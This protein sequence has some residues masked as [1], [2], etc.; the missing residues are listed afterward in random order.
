MAHE[1]YSC[2]RSVEDLRLFM[3]H[4]VFAVWDFMCLLK[5]LQ[6][7]LTCVEIPWIPTRDEIARRLIN[8]IVLEEETGEDPAGGY[9]SHFELYL[10]AMDSA[11][12]DTSPVQAFV[13]ELRRGSAVPRALAR[14]QV[15]RAARA[16][17]ETTWQ[18]LS[19]GSLHAIAA[20]FSLGREEVIPEMF[21]GLLSELG[22]GEESTRDELLPFRQYLERHVRVDRDHHGPLASRLLASLCGSLDHKWAE[23][24]DAAGRA[25]HAR[26]ALWDG[27]CALVAAEG[28]AARDAGADGQ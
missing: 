24:R 18:T 10:R 17:V 4:H 27:V 26:L 23:A 7:R 3:E 11:G 9:A 21:E 15:P 25:L 14:A 5:G 8:E 22:M 6:Q 20:A 13:E 16:F 12:A 1:L 2:L 19:R 28:R